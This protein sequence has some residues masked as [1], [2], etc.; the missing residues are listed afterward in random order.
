MSLLFYRRP[1]YVVKL[2]GPMSLAQCQIYVDRTQK[3]RRAIPPELSFDNVLQNKA[4]PP[5]ALQD[6]MDYLVYVAHD[7]ENL[8]FWLWL[9]DYTKRFY[10]TPK[11]EQNLSPPWL[12][13]EQAQQH[14]NASDQPP[15]TAD[16]PRGEIAEYE[17]KLD[18]AETSLSPI[19]TPQY[20]KQSFIS[21]VAI[22]NKTVADSVDDANAQMGLKW[23]SFTIQPFRTE[24]NRVI[25]HYL[26]PNSPRELNLSHR[27]RATVLHALQHT[28]HPSALAPVKAMVEANLRGQSHPNFIRWSICNGNKPRVL[29]VRNSGIAHV[30][31]GLILGILLV[32]SGKSRWWRFFVAP[33]F[34][35]G[36]SISV[37][38]YKG[39]CV[40]FHSTHCRGLRPWEQFGDNASL[41]TLGGTVDDEATLS[42][43]DVYSLPQ[44]SKRAISLDT[45]GTSNSFGHELWVDK[46]RKTPLIRKIF[47][48]QIWVQDQTVRLLQDRIVIQSHIWSMLIT[49]PLTALFVALPEFNVI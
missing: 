37:A 42:T 47:S 13:A 15:R 41:T 43:D 17:F 25:S 19:N 14:G 46:Y 6:F 36:I 39:L 38:A 8:Q 3:H 27:T 33:L 45:F 44:R 23:Q 11:N 34:L 30:I 9:Q 7:A 32:L 29:F 10:A 26:A 12:E 24:I 4:L 16:K 21:G 40:I 2:P 49:V 31:G 18:H 5:C 20:D 1:D 22:S 35:I 48:R 28:T